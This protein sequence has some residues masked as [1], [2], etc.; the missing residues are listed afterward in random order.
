MNM[1][2]NSLEI[3]TRVCP[4]RN[5]ESDRVA[6]ILDVRNVTSKIGTNTKVDFAKILKDTIGN[7]KCV[8]AIAV[9]GVQYD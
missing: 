2:D 8:A 7:R 1:I 4:Y 6:L 5:D 9:D 3:E